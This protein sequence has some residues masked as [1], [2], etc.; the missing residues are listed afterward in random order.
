MILGFLQFSMKSS[1]LDYRVFYPLSFPAF[2]SIRVYP[3]FLVYNLW[4]ISNEVLGEIESRKIYRVWTGIHIQK[5]KLIH[6]HHCILEL[7]FLKKTIEKWNQMISI[8]FWANWQGKHAFV[9]HH[10]FLFL[11]S[12]CACTV[13]MWSQRDRCSLGFTHHPFPLLDYCVCGK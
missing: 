5:L 9:D 12:L 1:I 10:P 3:F 13:S 4:F 7:G 11:L 6:R 2:F 8:N